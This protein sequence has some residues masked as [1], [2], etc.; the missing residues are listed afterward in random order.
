VWPLVRSATVLLL[1][2]VG[3]AVVG[4]AGWVLTLIDAAFT[5]TGVALP[6]V[7]PPDLDPLTV[8]LAALLGAAGSRLRPV[9]H[10]VTFLHELAH[11]LVA[12]ACGARPTGVVLRRVG[13]SHATYRSPTRGALRDRLYRA[14][15]AAAG[16]PAAAWFAAA[17]AGLLAAA[18][19]RPVLWVLAAFALL[20]TALSRSPWAA[21]VSLGLG[22]IAVVALSERAEPYAAG[23]VVALTVA[24]SLRNLTEDVR[25]LRGRLSERDDARAVQAAIGLPARLVRALQ[26]AVTLAATGVVARHLTGALG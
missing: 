13:G 1:V 9:A 3:L 19:P 22:A 17:G 7:E 14:A 5:R 23:V 8:L 18:G 6:P 20:V 15:T 2:L 16:Y 12:T 26:A 24:L 21:V 10:A 4:R 25:A 11:V